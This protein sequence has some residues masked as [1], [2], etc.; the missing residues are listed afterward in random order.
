MADVLRRREGAV[1]WIIISNYGKLNALTYD[2]WRKMPDAVSELE[3]DS[4]VRV[5]AL[6]GDGNSAFSSGADVAEFDTT[7]ESAGAVSSYNWVVDQATE[8]I[9]RCA[10]PT[11]ARIQGPCIGGGVALA[12]HCD[13]RI[14]SEDAVF[15]LPGAKLGLGISYANTNRLAQIVGLGYCA[16]IQFTGR[17]YNAQEA[18]HMRLVNKVVPLADLDR[19]FGEYCNDIAGNAP[20]S[21]AVMKRSLIEGQKDPDKRDLRQVNAMVEDCYAS[22]DYREGRAAFMQKRKPDFKGR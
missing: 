12:M 15:S 2:I 5:I 8:A 22:Q 1:G 10:K 9:A 6:R 17:T 4:A 13:A 3:R 18:L 16:E 19:I 20:L 14:C 11:L 21:L 7:R